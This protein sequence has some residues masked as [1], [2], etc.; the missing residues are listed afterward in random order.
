METV[1][2]IK[3]IHMLNYTW[4][5]ADIACSDNALKVV[6]ANGSHLILDSGAKIYDAVSSWWC[7]PLGHRHQLVSDSITQQL[8][9]F[10]HHIPAGLYNDVIE[11]VSAKLIQ[12]S[13]GMDKV[14]Y[15]SD[16]SSAVEMAM[17]L[18]YEYR[19]L[20]NEPAKTKFIALTNAY[21]G[22]TIFTLSVCGINSYKQ[23]YTPFLMQN[24]FI[25]DVCYVSSRH[26]P[27]WEK[28][29]TDT[30]ALEEYIA[31]ISSEVTALLIEPIVQGAGGL[32]II[33]KD[34]LAKL[35]QIAQKYQ[36]HVICDEIMVG[37][38][39]IGYSCVT[40]EL[41]GEQAEFICVAKNL[42]AGSIPMSAVV[43]SQKISGLF[44]ELNK[45]FPHSHTHSCNAL[46]AS[47]ASNYLTHLEQT[48]FKPNILKAEPLLFNI[49]HQLSLKY[50][51][52]QNV[53]GIGGI[54]A[55]NINLP[56]EQVARIH[57]LGIKYG[58]YLRPIGTNL[59][60]MPP[61][62]NLEHDI[63]EINTK[64]CDVFMD[65]I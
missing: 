30:K 56:S 59:Y 63:A 57:N 19:L 51:F 44:K 42:T 14:M 38:G 5:P 20:N 11:D 32:K 12:L 55:C 3:G 18:S 21:H 4:L 64:L 37:L 23:A 53:R 62:Y 6:K 15:A 2:V 39:R 45:L 31:K 46:A 35:I 65:L 34:F 16:G 22:E 29:N 13:K 9:Q 28:C 40:S 36:I 61:L 58:I 1:R 48:P 33:S 25:N 26:D 47:V 60:L 7:K 54:A 41:I 8:S 49:F 17:K 10:E 50:A 27:L 43:I 24:Y 52:I